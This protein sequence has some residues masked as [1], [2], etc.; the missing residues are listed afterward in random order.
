MDDTRLIV[1]V[2]K[3]QVLYDPHNVL[4]KDLQEKEKAWDEVAAAL[5]ADGN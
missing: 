4:Y 1:E 2:E 5:I 3:Y